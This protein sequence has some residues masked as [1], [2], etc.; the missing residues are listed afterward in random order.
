M[1][2]ES[3]TT[4]VIAVVQCKHVFPAGNRCTWYP[5]DHVHQLDGVCANG[6]Y[7]RHHKYDSDHEHRF[8]RVCADC[9]MQA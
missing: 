7:E 3:L 5:N 8:V 4:R 6:Q 1:S 9:G 2:A